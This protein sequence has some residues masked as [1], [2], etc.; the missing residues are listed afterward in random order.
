MLKYAA[1]MALA[2]AA[3]PAL[4]QSTASPPAPQS[5]QS[6]PQPANSLPPGAAN[7]SPSQTPYVSGSTAGGTAAVGAAPAVGPGSSGATTV[8]TPQ[9]R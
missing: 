5:G 2:L 8:T 4:A 1:A 7:M 6:M 9:S 3:G